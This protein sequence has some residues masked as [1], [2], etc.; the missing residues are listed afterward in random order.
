MTEGSIFLRMEQC[1]EKYGK[2]P[3][4]FILEEKEIKSNELQY[5]PGALEGICGHHLMG[6]SGNAKDFCEMIK[7]YLEMDA[8]EALVRFESEE[9]VK[10]QIATIRNELLRE[11]YENRQEYDA[12]KLKRLAA[13]F[14]ACGNKVVSVKVGLSLLNLFDMSENDGAKKM[15]KILA[16][17]E[18]FTDYVIWNSNTWD[19]KEK[20][21]LYFELAK[22][23]SGWGKINAVEMMQA[24]TE[25]KKDWLLRH[26][27]KNTV[28]YAYLGYECAMKCDLHERLQ[29]GCLTDEEFAG[30]SDIISGLLDE[31]PCQGMSAL[32]APVELSCLYLDECRNH[33]WDAEQVAL[34]TDLAA[35][36]KGSE[37]ENARMVVDKVD[38]VLS[39]VDMNAFIVENIDN[40][41]HNCLRIAKMYDIDMSRHLLRLMKM[42]FEKYYKFCSY[43]FNDNCC[44]D[45]F[46]DLCDRKI[47]YSKYPNEMG[48]LLGLGTVPGEI[49]LDM[50]VQ[51]LDKHYRKGRNMIKV[52]IQSPI[53]RWR[54]VAAKAL[55]GWVKE[56]ERT[57]Q[58]IDADLY[59]EVKR[60]AEIECVSQTKQMWEKLL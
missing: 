11:I 38:D 21:D 2:L 1:I 33:F 15:L 29:K 16:Y 53:T 39:R 28:L 43:F 23:L 42:D 54:N 32:D 44:V 35:Y 14:I 48:E 49:R 46:L 3:E 37:I 56:S 22:S 52:C 27:C 5:A 9:A 60:V 25:E 8:A 24:D 57:L 13:M 31:G 17:S 47:D 6:G 41:T 20:Q 34:I 4:D 19:E 12:S 7:I 58:S 26:G 30:A 45:E 51:Y 18:E 36:F 55:L 50:M 10:F 40:S 59:Q